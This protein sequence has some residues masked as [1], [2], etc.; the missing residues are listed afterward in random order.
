LGLAWF[1]AGAVC[2]TTILHAHHASSQVAPRTTTARMLAPTTPAA[3][4]GDAERISALEA[5]LTALEARS[6]AEQNNA[7]VLG[8][9]G[10]ELRIA[11][12]GE[13]KLRSSTTLT[14][15]GSTTTTLKAGTALELSST[16]TALLSA[17]GQTELRSPVLHLGGTGGR[18]VARIGDTVA[19]DKVSSGASGVFAR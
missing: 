17:A 18:P 11:K 16:G 8:Y 1:T 14:L 12:S 7:L 3:P 10:S 5:R 13:I 19:A 15:E 6:F 2:A 4:V 9:G